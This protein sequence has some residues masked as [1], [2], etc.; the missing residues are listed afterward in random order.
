MAL[1]DLI[2]IPDAAMD[3]G[4]VIKLIQAE[5][6]KLEI[7][8]PTL[9][10]IKQIDGSVQTLGM[11]HAKLE[12]LIKVCSARVNVLLVGPAGSGK[13][14][15]AEQVAKAFSLPFYFNGAISSEYKL[16][17][18]IDAQG[19]LVSTAFREA[20]EN[21][22]VYLFDEVDGSLPA[23]TLAFNAALANGFADFPDGRVNRHDDFICIAAANTY[24]GGAT[25]DFVGRNKQDGAFMDRFATL[26]WDIDEALELAAC[27]N[28][29]WVRKVQRW[30]A[31][32]ASKG[33]KVIISPRAS[34][35]GAKLL[36]AGLDEPTVAEMTVVKG[37]TPDQWA[38]IR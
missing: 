6:A 9:L 14:Y 21:G 23:A 2:E 25:F 33:L 28:T 36:S 3:E 17:G 22:G 18:F 30:R 11:S 16:S 1:S 19:R 10:E 8:R 15:A 38:S 26:R 31:N 7:P 5:I 29:G 34:F 37:M 32:A 12:T 27:P 24:G 13:T 20:Y 4:A 35:N